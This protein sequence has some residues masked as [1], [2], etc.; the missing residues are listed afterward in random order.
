VDGLRRRLHQPQKHPANPVLRGETPWEGQSPVLAH[1]LRDPASGR[2]RMWY[3]ARTSY[4]ERG[5]T[6][7]LCIRRGKE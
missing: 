3:R 2:F 5:R 6:Q 4:Q 1:V 7:G